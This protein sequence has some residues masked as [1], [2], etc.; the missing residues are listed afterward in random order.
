MPFELTIPVQTGTPWGPGL[1]D[2]RATHAAVLQALAVSAPDRAQTVH[3]AHVN[4]FTQA[5]LRTTTEA[6]PGLVWRITL[7]QDALYEPLLEG[8]Y[9]APLQRVHDVDVQLALPA[10][11]S[12]HVAYDAL[13][14]QPAARRHDIRFVTPTTFHR[15]HLHSPLPEPANCWQSWWTRWQAFAPPRLAINI[16]AL[17]IAAAHLAITRFR[18]TSRSASA[19]G[20]RLIGA[21]GDVTYILVRAGKLEPAW[22]QALTAL[23]AFAPFCGTGHKTALGLGQTRWAPA[24]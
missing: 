13:Y 8:L 10:L 15:Q 6:G 11:A 1:D 4:P 9:A 14:Q 20:W 12:R 22:L 24:A 21:V 7:L 2:Q 18:L 19:P 17:D 3:D 5:L 23:A 16:A